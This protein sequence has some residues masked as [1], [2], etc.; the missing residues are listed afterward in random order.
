MPK[1]LEKRERRIRFVKDKDVV[2]LVGSYLEMDSDADPSD[3]GEECFD[4]VAK[5]ARK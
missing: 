2:R 1:K 4:L 3:V 5:E